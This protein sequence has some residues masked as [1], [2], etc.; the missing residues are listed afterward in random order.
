MATTAHDLH[1]DALAL[2]QQGRLDE[3][4]ALLHRALQIQPN[5]AE[6]HA[7]LG[8]VFVHQKKY[9]EA[10]AQYQEALHL[11]PDLFAAHFI[12]AIALQ[13]K[14][15]L[16]EAEV[17]FRQALRVN[18]AYAPAHHNLGVVLLTVGRLEEA[19][20]CF[21]QALR[22]DAF[23]VDA[24]N[25][26]GNALGQQQKLPEAISC[27]REALRLN[28]DRAEI[29]FNLAL[30][31]EGLDQLDL[32][33]HHHRQALRRN[34]NYAE[35]HIN[36]GNVLGKQGHTDLAIGCYQQALAANP[37]SAEAYNNLGLALEG[38]DHLHEAVDCYEKA[39]QNKPGWVAAL[40]NLGNVHWQE[41]RFDEALSC[42]DQALRSCPN[43]PQAHLNR[44]RLRILLGDWTEGWSEYQWRWQTADWPGRLLRQPR[45]DGSPLAG[46]T[47]L[48]LAEQGL[49]D[50][51]QL[52][53]YVPLVKQHGG[54]VVVECQP[55]LVR[56]LTTIPGIDQLVAQGLALPAFDVHAS[57]FS[58][59]GL[60]Q[61]T[62]A[63]VPAAVPYLHAD[64]KLVNH[65]QCE[66]Q[67]CDVR[68]AKSDVK[69]T[70]SNI[71]HRASNIEPVFKIG[72]AWQG[73]PTYGYDR[74]R[75]IPLAHFSRLAQVE[76]VQLVCLQKGPGKKQLRAMEDRFGVL[77]LGDNL[78]EASS[79]FMDTAAIMKNLDLV[80]TSDTAVAHLAGSLGVPVWVGLPF[81]PD[82]RW[83]L[84]RADSPWYPSMRLFRQT[85]PGE[86]AD[87]FDRMARDLERSVRHTG[88]LPTYSPPAT[89]ILTDS[90]V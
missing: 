75:S 3:A 63:N 2:I 66:L 4:A 87:V 83:M 61:T 32:A 31:L 57:F 73:N 16:D 43:S 30:A 37:H 25:N 55:A 59:P 58:L 42:F 21:H 26:L 68:R 76:R 14:G 64:T 12:L 81:V 72:L 8:N 80:I 44:A 78:D 36:L 24:Y 48:L 1:Q 18:P 33:I 9:D 49:G 6:T 88:L 27:Y 89:G 82:W 56:F 71:E 52:I 10:I 60:L 54:K 53:R 39:L 90:G 69:S 5:Y 19:V 70:P 17:H 84:E 40:N 15:K 65:W 28:P 34:A 62:L 85:K 38:K 29:H 13:D 74:R 23:F 45:W 46:R 86:W 67:K 7:S 22:L 51:L 79:A 50:T 35:A 77:D 20:V 11:N 41:G 47:L